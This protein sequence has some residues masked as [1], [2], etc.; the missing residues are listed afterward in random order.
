VRVVLDTNLLISALISEQGAP[1]R[2]LDAW[3]DQRFVLVSS[4]EQLQEF[5]TVSRRERLAR[6]IDRNDVGRVINQIRAEALILEKLPRV[7]RSTDPADNFLL[8]MAEAGE[9]DYLVSGDRRGVL[10]L[11][12]HGRTQIVTVSA[13]TKTLGLESKPP[14]P[15]AKV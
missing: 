1:A 12:Q 10:V 11:A 2:L 15:S 6:F 4:T 14:K 5:K 7:D 8:A 3:D 9:A 13:M